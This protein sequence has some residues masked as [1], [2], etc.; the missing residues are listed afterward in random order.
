[1]RG[2]RRKSQFREDFCLHVLLSH[3]FIFVAA[4]WSSLAVPGGGW[5]AVPEGARPS[6]SPGSGSGGSIAIPNGGAPPAA[7]ANARRRG[8]TRREVGWTATAKLFSQ[9]LAALKQI[10]SIAITITYASP[11]SASPD[12]NRPPCKEYPATLHILN[13]VGQ[14]VPDMI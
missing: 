2:A 5:A 14:A 7:A 12:C 11:S 6:K 13:E 10:I 1:M 4:M 9:P 8:S 3:S